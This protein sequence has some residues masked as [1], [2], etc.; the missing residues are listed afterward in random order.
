MK[1]LEFNNVA[2]IYFSVSWVIGILIILFSLLKIQDELVL[3]L[4]FLSALSLIVNVFSVVLLFVLYYVFPE[5]KT[6]FK[7]SAILL[8]FNFPVLF[9]LYIILAIA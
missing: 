9:V 3:G 5:N 2:L 7:N 8:L 1:K 6:E 4:L